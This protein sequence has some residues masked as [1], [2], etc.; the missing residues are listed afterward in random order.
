MSIFHYERINP[1]FITRLGEN[2]LRG[3]SS[4]IIGAR[5]SGKRHVLYLLNQYLEEL[6]VGPII[7]LNF[8]ENAPI[9]GEKQVVSLL[10]KAVAEV[11]PDPPTYEHKAGDVLGP[12]RQLASTMERPIILLASNIDGMAHHL[13]RSFLEGARTLVECERRQLVAVM[14]G[15]DDF[16]EL[17][18]GPKSEFNCAEYFLLQ[19]YSEEELGQGLTHFLQQLSIKVDS[20]P[21]L[22]RHLWLHTGGNLYLL[23]IILWV[24]LQNRVNEGILPDEPLTVAEIPTTYRMFGTP[25][26]YGAH[27]FRYARELISRDQHCWDAL[28]SLIH[29]EA[30]RSGMQESAPSRL[31]LA[32][33]ATRVLSADGSHLQVASPIMEDFLRQQYTPLRFG[34]LYADVGAWEEAFKRYADLDL[35]E[36]MRPSGSEDRVE[37]ERIVGSLCASLYSEAAEASDRHPNLVIEKIQKLFAN[38][39]HYVLGF[40]EI[41][42]WRRRQNTEWEHSPFANYAGPG[43]EELRRIKELL[44]EDRTYS[45]GQ[46]ALEGEM[47][48]YAVAAVIP[49]LLFDQQAAV[50]VSDIEH[51]TSISRERERLIGQLL[52]HFIKAYTHAVT[53][54]QFRQRINSRRM[55]VETINSVFS[56][57]H[58]LGPRDLNVKYILSMTARKLRQLEYRR[59]L[60]CLVD[61]DQQVLEGVI[62]DC[63]EGLTSVAGLIRYK[64]SNPLGSVQAFVVNTKKSKIVEN[65]RAELLADKRVVQ[66]GAM[67]AFA[68]IPISNAAGEVIGTLL[69]ERDNGAP[70]SKDDVE[71]LESFCGSLAIAIE[72][73][74]RINLLESGL[75]KIPDPIFIV[76]SSVRPRYANKAASNLLGIPS[77]WHDP[78]DKVKPL[79]KS[80]VGEIREIIR[81]SLKYCYRLARHVEG[82]GDNPDYHGAVVSTAI[83]DER[84][85]VIGGLL[86]IQDLTYLYKVFEASHLIAQAGDTSGALRYMLES[87]KKLGHQW[88]RLY[89]T[90]VDDEGVMWFVS[91]DCFGYRDASTENDF[92]QGLVRLAPRS[93]ARHNDWLCIERAEPIVFCWEEKEEDGAR[94]VTASGLEALNWRDPK[95]PPHTRKQPGDFWIDLPL[96]VNRDK[97]LGKMC[98]QCDESLQPEDFV[99]LK[100]LSET[101]AQLL[102]T[103]SNMAEEAR[104]ISVGVAQQVLSTLAHNIGTRLGG[105][106]GVLADYQDLQDKLD[107]KSPL[108]PEIARNNESFKHILEQAFVTISG[109]NKR[110]RPFRPDVSVVDLATQVEKALSSAL[111]AGTWTLICGDRPLEVEIDSNLFETALLEIVQNSRDAVAGDGKLSVSV[112]LEKKQTA[113]LDAALITYRDNGPGVPTEY[114]DRIFDD[115]FSRRP[116]QDNIGTGLGLGFV[117]RVIT[118]HG[119]SVYYNPL[120]TEGAEF[121][122]TIPRKREPKE[123]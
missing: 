72:Q 98:L 122:I 19:G 15:E 54:Y 77:G 52:E 11:T 79:T 64:L 92:M 23:R 3:E 71:D 65:A 47:K 93:G 115:F 49:G 81:E 35:E 27:I 59:V 28:E 34:D 90:E 68:I 109:A 91:K 121:V 66:A 2:V 6:N 22:L 44:P 113:T 63:A 51:S 84:E 82:I 38:G 78:T 88:G 7:K 1:D 61:A 53:V 96:M 86:R 55:Q 30:V 42:F 110:L 67:E 31:E 4:V 76:D 69:V 89:L 99:F 118:A 114:K 21:D 108:R 25:G 56:I 39:C 120:Y 8:L 58:S 46:L 57:F 87:A 45:Q 75:D 119:G 10:L 50:V 16:H 14:S 9:Y 100:V 41:T 102:T 97:V 13:A 80:G 24:V 83:Q 116:G 106:P 103:Y 70:P 48:R 111:G 73:C 20:Y 5:Y 26:I 104:M 117:R 107:A 62:D 29:G 40:R 12:I 101:F 33:V 43:V 17:V 123:E 85:K 18:Y 60:F 74:R 37:T 32:G 36:R 95:Q 94:I 112:L 105:L